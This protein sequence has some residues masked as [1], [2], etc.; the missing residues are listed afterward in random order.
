MSAPVEIRWIFKACIYR[1]K[2]SAI[3]HT[4]AILNTLVVVFH[5]IAIGNYQSRK[6]MVS[7]SKTYY[8]APGNFPISL[9]GSINSFTPSS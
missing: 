1:A 2:F 9:T 8:S 4:T 6:V 5:E 3:A 7:G